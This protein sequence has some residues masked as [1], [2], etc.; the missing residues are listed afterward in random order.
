MEFKEIRSEL[1]DL[2]HRETRLLTDYAELEEENITL[3][4]QISNLRSSQ[5]EFE[6]SKHEIRHL[7]EEVDL[8]NQQV[9]E[10]ANLK[11]IAEKQL[12]EAL[13]SLQNERE[14]RYLLKKELDS[15]LNSDS[16]YQLGNLALSIQAAADKDG[17]AEE[18]DTDVE[19]QDS[20]NRCETQSSRC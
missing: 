16:M 15:K 6:G 1:R 20:L 13:E 8:L 2:K 7:S 19:G 17:K 3:Q 4:K 14:Q 11:K 18:E 12:E 5:V 10:L 9:E